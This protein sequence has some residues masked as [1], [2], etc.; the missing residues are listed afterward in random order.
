MLEESVYIIT[1]NVCLLTV[2]QRQVCLN[3]L[4]GN[5]LFL[6]YVVILV[7]PILEL[8]FCDFALG[9]WECSSYALHR[10]ESFYC[11][12]VSTDVS[13]FEFIFM[14]VK[15]SLLHICMA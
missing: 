13:K 15:I 8:L 5:F 11:V 12:H 14:G 2:S 7:C 10:P 4:L 1:Q 9:P 6:T 3:L